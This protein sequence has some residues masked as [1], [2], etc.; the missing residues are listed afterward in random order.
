[1][2]NGSEGD[3]DEDVTLNKATSGS[4]LTKA[5]N[6]KCTTTIQGKIACLPVLKSRKKATNDR[7][8]QLDN[9]WIGTFT[10]MPIRQN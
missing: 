7:K 10:G 2:T 6:R 4:M 1:L 8:V 5:E 3:D 9:G